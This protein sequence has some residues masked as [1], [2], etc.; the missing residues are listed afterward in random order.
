MTGVQTC[1]LPIWY[2][3]DW[4]GASDAERIEI[5]R[6][7]ARAMEVV[8]HVARPH[9]FNLGLNQTFEQERPYPHGHWLSEQVL[10]KHNIYACDPKLGGVTCGTFSAKR[11]CPFV[12]GA[13]SS[14]SSS[15]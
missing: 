10:L 1:A 4:T 9:G 12:S 15:R 14:P 7:T 13:M 5:G 11:T 3:A 2:V 6:L 8:R